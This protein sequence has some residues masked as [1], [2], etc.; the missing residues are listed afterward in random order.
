MKL[1]VLCL[2]P[3]LAAVMIIGPACEKSAEAN[4]STPAAEPVTVSLASSRVAPVQREVKVVGTLYGDEEATVSAK[5]PG[6]ITQIL[7]DVGDRVPAGGPLAQID[8]TD[9]ELAAAQK[10]MAVQASLAKL[11][12]DDFPPESFDLTRVPTVE[13]AR[14]QSA[15]AEA[16][17]QRGEKL[18]RQD[19]PLISPQD[20]A[21][22]QT[23]FEV[24]RSNYEVELLVAKSQLA[25]ARARKTE[26]GR[27]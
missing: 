22:L 10:R 26:I 6:R 4:R 18:F 5:V 23:A 7:L 21:D 13:R 11:G 8:R 14:L 3:L 1:P 9:Y 19:P 27:A 2:A 17:F 12:L 25:D 24:S 15:N 16:K 20:F